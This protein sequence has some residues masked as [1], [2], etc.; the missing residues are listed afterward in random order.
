MSLEKKNQNQIKCVFVP[1]M[2]DSRIAYISFLH[3]Q[4]MKKIKR[5]I[6]YAKRHVLEFQIMVSDTNESILL[7]STQ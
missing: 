1:C 5:K 6:I 7:H 2:H 4:K 3:N